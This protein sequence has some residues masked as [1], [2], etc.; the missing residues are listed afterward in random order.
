VMDGTRVVGVEE[1]VGIE[2]LHRCSGPSI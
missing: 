1:H 2:K